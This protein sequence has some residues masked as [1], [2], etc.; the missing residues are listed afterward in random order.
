MSSIEDASQALL[1][2]VESNAKRAAAAG[3]HNVAETFSRAALNAAEALAWIRSPG[4]SHG[5]NSVKGD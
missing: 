1:T 2:A 3:H 5:G 4:H